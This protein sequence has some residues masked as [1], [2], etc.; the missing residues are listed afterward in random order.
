MLC[1]TWYHLYN[2][3]IMKN[4]HGHETLKSVCSNQGFICL[5]PAMEILRK[6]VKYVPSQQ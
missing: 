4:A 6:C 2:L 1:T 3:K 5:K